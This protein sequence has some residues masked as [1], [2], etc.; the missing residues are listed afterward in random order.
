MPNVP[1][2]QKPDQAG[3]KRSWAP[4][5]LKGLLWQD[6]QR[7]MET[8][9]LPL[10]SKEKKQRDVDPGKLW[11]LGLCLWLLEPL[12]LLAKCQASTTGVV[13]A[14]TAGASAVQRATSS[15]WRFL[16]ESGWGLQ[17]ILPTRPPVAI[18]QLF[19]LGLASHLQASRMMQRSTFAPP[20]KWEYISTGALASRYPTT[21]GATPVTKP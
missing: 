19:T 4:W 20:C 17:Q 21:C 3:Q 18:M 9:K 6:S 12:P 13:C 5:T 1:I 15:A 11:F 10:A 16:G 7:G 14:G 8:P 2:K